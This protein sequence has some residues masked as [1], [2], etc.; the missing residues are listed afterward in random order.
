MGLSIS[1]KSLK[2]LGKV[3]PYAIGGAFALVAF[4]SLLG[5]VL[6]LIMPS[7]FLTSFLSTAPGGLTEMGLTA[8]ALHADIATVLAFQLFRLFFILLIVPPLLKWRLNR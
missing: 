3:F 6:T 5:F 8:I 2:Q 1:L 7:T 4:T